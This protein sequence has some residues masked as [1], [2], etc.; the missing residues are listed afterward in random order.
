M[1]REKPARSPEELARRQEKLEKKIKEIYEEL[2]AI[3]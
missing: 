1:E 3:K 2:Q